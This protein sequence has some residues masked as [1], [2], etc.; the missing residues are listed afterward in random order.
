MNKG[1]T[2]VELLATIII[3]SGIMLIAI[4]SYG[5]IAYSVKVTSLKNKTDAMSASMLKFASTYL[6]DDIKP[7]A[8]SCSNPL[9]CCVEYDLYNYVLIHGIYSA[10]KEKDGEKIVIDPLTNDKLNG[11]LRVKYNITTY[12]LEVEFIKDKINNLFVKKCEG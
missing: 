4:P 10:E 7:A 11:V 1:F 8:E 5:D 2:M 6:L 12:E 3:L 9:K